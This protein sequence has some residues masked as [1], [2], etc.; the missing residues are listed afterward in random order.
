MDLE[1]QI[2]YWIKDDLERIEALQTASTLHLN[3]WCIAAGFVRNLVWDKLHKKQSLTPLNDVDLIYFDPT[4]PN[5]ESDRLLERH[6]NSLS[7]LPWSVK[8]QARMHIRNGDSPYSS[9]CDAMSYWVEIETAVGVRLTKKDEIEMV[10]PFGVESLFESTITLNTKRAK[11]QDFYE[12]I[13]NKQWLS[14]WPNL[15]VTA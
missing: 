12:R 2:K 8:N 10:V 3:D 5:E 11:P 7:M 6:L 9:T 15:E 13:E 14:I 1:N 4:N